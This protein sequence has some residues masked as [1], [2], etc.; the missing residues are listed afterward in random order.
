[1]ANV[2]CAALGTAV[3]SATRDQASS[4]TG[5]D[6]DVDQVPLGAAEAVTQ[7]TEG[8]EVDLVVHPD[9]HLVARGKPATD[10]IAVPARHDRRRYRSSRRELD[11]ARNADA[12]SPDSRL[13]ARN[14]LH[15]LIEKVLDVGQ[16]LV[17][18][19]GEVTGLLMLL[20]YL[21]AEVGQAGLDAGG[22]ELGSEQQPRAGTE[23]HLAR[24]ATAG[25]RTEPAVSNQT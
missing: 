4:D 19:L 1:M 3:E 16:D 6:L 23:L 11:R 13:A 18:P 2:A 17:R 14:G 5:A 8:H 25:R 15:Q 21:T 9:W 24:C 20:D 12:D 10:V 22:T 7:L